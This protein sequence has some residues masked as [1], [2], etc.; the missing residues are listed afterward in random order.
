LLEIRVLT[1][2]TTFLARELHDELGQYLTAMDVLVTVFEKK[3]KQEERQSSRIL[4]NLAD[5]REILA[6]TITR[7]RELSVS[8]RPPILET[9][10]IS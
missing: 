5:M 10:G 3:V 2:D 8:L 4:K 1:P 7:S 6:G 9:S